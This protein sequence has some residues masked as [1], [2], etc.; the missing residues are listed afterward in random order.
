MILAGIAI[1]LAV[2]VM[3]DDKLHVVFCDVGQ[4][5]ATLISYKSKQILIDGGPDN[6]V[7]RCLAHH[8]P[9]YD[10]KI[11][12]VVLTHDNSDHS[13]GLVEVNK[14]YRVGVWEPRLHR[15]QTVQL[16]PVRMAVEWPKEEETNQAIIPDNNSGIVVRIKYGLFDVLMTADVNTGNYAADETVEVVKVPHH[17]SR[18]AITPAWIEAAK[19]KLA[20]ISVGKD[21][22]GQPAAEVI[23]EFEAA[24]ARVMRTDEAGDIEV[25]SDGESWRVK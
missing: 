16:G 5:D 1:W 8:M 18:L 7:L 24:G 10:R 23:S 4:G 2:G 13:T 6:S 15:G 19:P 25:I 9:F 12:V 3:P 14:R 22:F 20:V 17:G 21:S 11:D